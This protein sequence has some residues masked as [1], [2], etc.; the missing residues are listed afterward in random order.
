MQLGM[1]GLGRMGSNLV[2][3]LMGDGHRCVVS[4]LDAE[5]VATVEA[6]GATAARDLADLVDR[7]EQPRTVWVMVPAGVAGRVIDAVAEHLD[8]GDCGKS[9][10]ESSHSKPATSRGRRPRPG[11]AGRWPS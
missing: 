3:R 2:R 4:D 1:I 9:G 8:P 6:E 10:R 7:L 11:S 5:A